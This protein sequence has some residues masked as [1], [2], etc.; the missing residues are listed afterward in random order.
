MDGGKISTQDKCVNAMPI[1][2]L[3][4]IAVV[5]LLMAFVF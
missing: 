3:A 1:V 5:G 4:V 2:A